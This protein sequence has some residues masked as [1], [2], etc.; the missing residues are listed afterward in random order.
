MKA[1]TALLLGIGAGV[2]T[3]AVVA[4][5]RADR[6]PLAVVAEGR[7]TKVE[8][9]DGAVLTVDV[10]GPEDGPVVLLAHCWGGDLRNWDL[11][12]GPLVEDGHRVVRWSQR[13]HGSSTVGEDGYAIER[14]GAD[15]A[16]VLEALDLQ[17]VVVAG[18]SLGGMTTQAF[19]IWHPEVVQERVK[20][21]V[22]VGTS[23][24][25]L[26]A[27]P[28][29]RTERLLR[30][31][32]LDRVLAGP[33]GH[34]WVRGALGKGATPA[35]VRATRD[36]FVATPHE[37]RMGIADAMLAMDL[38]EGRRQIDVPTTI[39]V[40]TRDTLTPVA[41]SR[42]M[43]ADIPGA[44]LEVLPGAGHMLPFE[45]PDVV[46]RAIREIHEGAQHEEKVQ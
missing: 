28:I 44:R 6:S 31:P 18:H 40:G 35:M 36:H 4:N 46:V 39:V 41:H 32:R 43:A 34:V 29:A 9:S 33:G 26:A 16:E 10:T 27:S 23:S 8:T 11:V 15:L 19:A 22:L 38:H 21:L 30:N 7:R 13:G 2:A 1:R 5:R 25:R 37:V 20:G 17:D 3:A 12:A 14:F 24:G 42:S 45:A